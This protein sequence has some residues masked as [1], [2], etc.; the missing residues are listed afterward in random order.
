MP[1]FLCVVVLCRFVTMETEEDAKDTALDLRLKK[2]NFRGQ[3]VKARIKT[4]PVVRSFFPVSSAVPPVAPVY[5]PLHL[6]F[7]PVVPSPMMDLANF[8]YL[9]VPPAV[10][11]TATPVVETAEEVP[12]TSEPTAVLETAEAPVEEAD[13]T[14]T[15]E[16]NS[17]GK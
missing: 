7:P 8:G 2:R 12:V 10:D 1:V 5:P 4:E 9:P 11:P 16:V 14:S 15:E 3:S 6:P 17:E 13:K